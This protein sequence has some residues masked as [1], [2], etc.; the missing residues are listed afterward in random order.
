MIIGTQFYLLLLDFI[1]QDG[2]RVKSYLDPEKINFHHPK[3]KGKYGNK[4]Y[5]IAA[6][7]WSFW[8]EHSWTASATFGS[9]YVSELPQICHVLAYNLV[10]PP[11][12]F[13]LN[14]TKWGTLQ[15]KSGIKS[16]NRLKWLG[17]GTFQ[18][19]NCFYFLGNVTTVLLSTCEILF[20]FMLF[21]L[22]PIW[23]FNIYWANSIINY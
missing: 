14:S 8:K 18:L 19:K 17:N 23:K 10:E 16:W 4:A 12:S 7:F 22:S 9:D 2:K 3:G 6:S 21:D 11:F 20:I 5:I 13:R 15:L 1:S